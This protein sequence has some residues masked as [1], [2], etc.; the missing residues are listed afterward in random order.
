MIGSVVAGDS[1]W[2]PSP[3]EPPTA[4]SEVEHLLG[5]LNRQRAT[6]RWKADGLDD[7]GLAVR[8]GASAMSLGGL[9]LHLAAVEVL[10]STWRL[11]GSPPLGPWDPSAWDTSR[12]WAATFDVGDRGAAELYRM[13]DDAVVR[14]GERFAA[15]LERGG[16][17]QPVAVSAPDGERASLRRLLFDLLEEYGRHT[18]HADVLREAADGRVGE[19]PPS[20]W[21]SS[22]R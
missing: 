8:V 5:A 18:G 13:Y 20:D 15:A 12:G 9:L 21:Q 19:D 22:A 3:W 10:Y 17:D 4:A 14:S 1:S 7:G 2:A 11:D 16:L 6:F